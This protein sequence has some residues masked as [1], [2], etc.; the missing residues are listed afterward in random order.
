MDPQ[1][2]T[3]SLVCQGESLIARAPFPSNHA[4]EAVHSHLSLRL[5]GR[6]V[7][8]FSVSPDVAKHATCASS[9][10]LQA[11]SLLNCSSIFNQ[12]IGEKQPEVRLACLSITLQKYPQW[13]W[14]AVAKAVC[15]IRR[16]VVTGFVVSVTGSVGKHQTSHAESHEPRLNR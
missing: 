9:I 16:H 6:F 7:I 11:E 3:A 12:Q 2:Y 13:G 15:H 8:S 5:T 10:A 1:P 14:P 4:V